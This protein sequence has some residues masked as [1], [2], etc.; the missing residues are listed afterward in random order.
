MDLNK[1]FI[2]L[3][4]LLPTSLFGAEAVVSAPK[5]AYAGQIFTLN[6]EGSVGEHRSW[7][8]DPRL[9]NSYIVC[10]DKVTIGYSA[11]IPGLYTFYLVVSDS[12]GIDYKKVQVQVISPG[13]APDDPGEITCTCTFL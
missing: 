4:L 2:I 9:E 12:E 8:H 7:I 3:V 11:A 13:S 1:L 10:G 5:E 6:S